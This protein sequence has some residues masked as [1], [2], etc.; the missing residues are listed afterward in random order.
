MKI[1]RSILEKDRLLKKAVYKYFKENTGAKK[2]DIDYLISSHKI[3]NTLIYEKNKYI[4]VFNVYSGSCVINHLIG[5]GCGLKG[6]RAIAKEIKSRY[7]Y[8]KELSYERAFK[9]NSK[10]RKYPIERFIK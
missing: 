1:D 3:Y 7:K 9:Q 5:V 8:V 2:K 6:I 4:C 10:W